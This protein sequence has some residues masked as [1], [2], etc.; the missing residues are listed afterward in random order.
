MSNTAT[1]LITLIMLLQRQ[2]NQQAA[3]LAA[4]L[5]V[6]VRTFHRYITM[7]DEMGI[8]VYSERGPYGGFSLVRGY[9]MAPL[10]FTP[11]E[12]V[13]VSLGTSLVGEL[14]G[15]L[16]REAVNGAAAKLDNV[17][18]EEQR[19]EV[20]WAKRT[21]IATGMHRTEQG[22]VTEFLKTLRAA[23]HERQ[24]I[25]LIYR[26]RDGEVTKRLVDPYAL[27]HRWGWWYV[28]GYCHLRKN[29]RSLRVDRIVELAILPQQFVVPSEF[30]IQAYLAT[31]PVA[32]NQQRVQLRFAPPAARVA[33]ENRYQWDAIHEETD[34]SALVTLVTPDLQWAASTVL[35]YGGMA[36]AVAPDELCQL[37]R[38]Y[39]Q[40]I[41]A[42]YTN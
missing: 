14:W 41:A 33:W 13:V 11:E 20:V 40:A 35:A 3:D 19:H 16:Y 42:Q 36:V 18:P 5:G 34:G 7:L 17:L 23:T 15:P 31:E 9:K 27:V 38:E 2:P 22:I 29:V 8:P 37:V 24:T 25:Q 39:A 32:A 28:V 10:V 12:A 4:E 30:D 6:S 26:S 1:R 21:L